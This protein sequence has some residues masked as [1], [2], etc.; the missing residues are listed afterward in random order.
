MKGE[1]FVI[2]RLRHW[3]AQAVA[4]DNPSISSTLEKLTAAALHRAGG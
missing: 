1:V 2:Q 3:A 4:R